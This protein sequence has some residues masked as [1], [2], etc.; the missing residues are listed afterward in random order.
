M[1][2]KLQDYV[3]KMVMEDKKL[4]ESYQEYLDKELGYSEI[5]EQNAGEILEKMAEIQSRKI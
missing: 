4:L 1:N 3:Q 5:N 2:K